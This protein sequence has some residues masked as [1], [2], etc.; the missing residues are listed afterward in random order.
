MSVIRLLIVLCLTVLLGLFAGCQSNPMLRKQGMDALRAHDLAMAGARFAQAVKQDPTDW[1]AHHYL[2]KVYLQ[3]HRALDAKLALE[4]SLAQRHDAVEKPMILDD[5]AEA[6]YRL[7]QREQLAQLLVSAAKQ[8]HAPYAFRRQGLYL[9]KIEDIDGAIVAF[10][11]AAHF[12]PGDP[13]PYIDLANL[14]ESTHRLEQARQS[15]R[16]AYGIEPKNS[17]VNRRLRAYG[18]IPGPTIALPVR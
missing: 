9:Q 5:L 8:S 3:Q 14:Y 17:E 6:L 11:K 12:G 7:D 1:K 15:L 10:A 2:G 13:Q 18:I 4:K 16:R